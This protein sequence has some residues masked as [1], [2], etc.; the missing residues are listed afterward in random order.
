MKTIKTANGS[1]MRVKDDEADKMVSGKGRYHKGDYSYCG[2][3]E[4]KN[5]TKKGK[6]GRW[7]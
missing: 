7:E 3:E 6:D 2:K 1:I 4:W 5:S